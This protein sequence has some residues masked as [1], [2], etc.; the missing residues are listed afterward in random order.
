MVAADELEWARARIGKSAE[1]RSR[2]EDMIQLVLSAELWVNPR[3]KMLL[4]VK[5]SER[6]KLVRFEEATQ[7]AAG[8]VDMGQ[9]KGA[10]RTGPPRGID[11]A[12]EQTTAANA[13]ISIHTRDQHVPRPYIGEEA[14]KG[15]VVGGVVSCR[16]A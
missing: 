7:A 2:D 15:G 3:S 1:V 12:T 6:S 13:S 14:A 10:D 16:V 9:P 11:V 4:L 8:G 5:R